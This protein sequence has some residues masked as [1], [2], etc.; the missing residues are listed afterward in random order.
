V[1]IAIDPD[2]I[3]SH[4]IDPALLPVL[5]AQ[6]RELCADRCGGLLLYHWPLRAPTPA[7]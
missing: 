3:T 1:F 5:R 6:A 7:S 2:R 4:L